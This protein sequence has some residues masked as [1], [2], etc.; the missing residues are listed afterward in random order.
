MRGDSSIRYGL[1]TG[2]IATKEGEINA[3]GRH[4]DLIA[5]TS[6]GSH[7]VR[8]SGDERVSSD[9]LNFSSRFESEHDRAFRFGGFGHDAD[10][11]C[12]G[13]GGYAP[14]NY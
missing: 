9:Q 6:F 13:M 12:T 1:P 3:H 8:V 10:P 11:R 14:R 7:Q 5:P 2:H 4:V